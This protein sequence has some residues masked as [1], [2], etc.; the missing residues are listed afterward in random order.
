MKDNDIIEMRYNPNAE[1]N[2]FWEPLRIRDDKRKPQ[3]FTI[4]NSVWDTI[5]NPVSNDFIRNNVKM[6]DFNTLYNDKS[7]NKYYV[8][9]DNYY[10]NSLRKLHN[11]IKTKLI[12]GVC[13]TFNEPI[14]IL[15]MSIGRGGDLNKS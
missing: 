7:Q 1:N 15:D 2:M 5:V 6:S 12:V 10:T 8:G 11:Y 3:F 4:A 9:D 13:S 14:Q